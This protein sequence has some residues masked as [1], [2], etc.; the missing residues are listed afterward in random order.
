MQVDQVT[1]IGSLDQ[2]GGVDTLMRNTKYTIA[3]IW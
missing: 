3:R 1:D 2:G